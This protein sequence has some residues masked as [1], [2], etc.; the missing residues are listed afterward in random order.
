MKVLKWSL[1]YSSTNPLV[2]DMLIGVVKIWVYTLQK[3]LVSKSTG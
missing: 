3:W 2:K 1:I